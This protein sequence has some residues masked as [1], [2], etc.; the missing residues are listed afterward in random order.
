MAGFDIVAF[1]DAIVAKI[2]ATLPNTTLYED[3]IPDD[4]NLERDENLKLKPYMYLRFG[5]IKASRNGKSFMGPR[6]DEYFGTADI[7]AVAP[8]GRIARMMNQAMVD[9]LIGFRPDGINPMS[10][11]SDEGD[12]SQFVVTSNEARPT[13]NIAS[14]RM[15]FGVNTLDRGEPLTP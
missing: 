13:Q 5:P 4:E 1:Q 2:K 6:Q 15:R 10:L 9:A 3:T 12:P 14:T 8:S 7:V 11:R